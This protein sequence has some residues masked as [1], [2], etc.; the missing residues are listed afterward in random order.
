MLLRA[1]D[2]NRALALIGSAV[3]LCVTIAALAV[4]FGGRASSERISVAIDTSYVGQGITAGTAVVMHGIVVGKVTSVATLPGG[5]V[6]LV[7]DLEKRPA[8]GLTDAVNI[9]FR[10]VNYFGVPG[11]NILPAAG[12]QPLHDGS[13]IRLV[14]KGN[15]TLTELL[16]QLG[17]VSAGTLTPQLISVVDRIT[18]Y[19]D[20]LNPLL[21]T[22]LMVTTA[23]ADVQTASTAQ[24]LV[25]SAATGS[26]L[27]GFVDSAIEAGER[28]TSLNTPQPPQTAPG[29]P[30]FLAGVHVPDLSDESQE[31]FLANFK[32][33][34]DMIPNGVFAA[35]G[36][37]ESS[38]VD[39]LLPLVKG[40]T[41]ITDTVP[42]LVRPDDFAQTMVE[43]R[44]R[45]ET[46]YAGTPEQRALQVRVVLDGLPG[47]AAPLGVPGG[48]E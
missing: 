2:E 33:F 44:R 27:P 25:N 6:R 39:D 19:T 24:L 38:H 10:P 13:Q 15:S 34:L 29:Q 35:M 11:V 5:S 36:K 43:L 3:V 45:F 4:T 18:R 31:Y 46:L 8:A 16:S 42:T 40:I 17:D 23:V 21:E 20:G 26:A 14:P 37:L 30:P 22:M 7:T 1:K 47:V 41:S 32:P 28:F 48:G 12:G 9:D